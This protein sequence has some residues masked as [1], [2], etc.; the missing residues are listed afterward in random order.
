M[1]AM[2]LTRQGLAKL[3]ARLGIADAAD[4]R[5]IIGESA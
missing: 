3:M 4:E 1:A 2:G 5:P